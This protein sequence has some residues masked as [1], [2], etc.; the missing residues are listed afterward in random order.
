ME[1][2][3]QLQGKG[4]FN[5]GI[6]F[7]V[8]EKLGSAPH[9][10]IGKASEG[11]PFGVF[12]GGWKLKAFPT[13]EIDLEQWNRLRLHVADE[14]VQGWIN[15]ELVADYTLEK[16]NLPAGKIA[17]QSAAGKG[18]SGTIRFRNVKV[19]RL[20]ESLRPFSPV[21]DPKTSGRMELVQWLVDREHPLTARVMVNRVWHHLMGQPLVATP[22]DFGFY[23][24][25][26]SHPELLDHLGTRFIENGWSIKQLIRDI[27]LTRTY[28]LDS[29]CDLQTARLDPDN[30]WLARHSRRRLDAERFVTVFSWL[31]DN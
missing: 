8:A 18:E 6:S 17:L 31:R 23:G 11:E 2:D 12:F 30:K 14:K 15:D 3:F 22:D 25:R 10:N 29:R 16:K 28:G 9:F 19:Q 13:E 4:R 7:R 20:D 27:V 24:S 26:P 5:S 21:K 1:C